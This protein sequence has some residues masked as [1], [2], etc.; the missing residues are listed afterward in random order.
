MSRN[1]YPEETVARI[2]D[3]SMGLFLEK[4]YERTTIQDIVDNLDGLT[5]GAIYHHF[6]SKEEILDAALDRADAAAFRRYD[7]IIADS[8]MTGIEKLQA[9]LDLSAS[10]S[11]MDLTPK[12]AI[13]ADPVK[14]ARLLGIMYRSLLEEVVPRYVEPIVRQGMAD[15]TIE[16]EQPRELAETV[17]LLAN[18]WVVPLFQALTE[19]R[20]RARMRFYFDMLKRM[21]VDLSSENVE[22]RIESFRRS[23]E[24]E[25]G[26]SA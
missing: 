21:G 1:K 12:M 10:S 17:V 20:L 13:D 18:L 7:E 24:E 2:L 5:K 25:T 14:N 4:G 19:E 11:Q 26:A 9:M 3:V 8:A 23:R 6:K 15:G 16:T 22:K